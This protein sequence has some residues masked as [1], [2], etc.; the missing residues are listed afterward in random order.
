MIR[1]SRQMIRVSLCFVLLRMNLID[2]HKL[3]FNCR[4]AL[5]A[6]FHC[7][8]EYSGTRKVCDWLPVRISAEEKRNLESHHDNLAMCVCV[9]ARGFKP[10]HVFE[11][12]SRLVTCVGGREEAKDDSE[13]SRECVHV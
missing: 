2:T 5:P 4:R 11:A 7:R 13:R 8:E 9:R 3:P 1:S 6:S 10:A 12:C